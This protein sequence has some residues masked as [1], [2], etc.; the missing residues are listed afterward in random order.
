MLLCM[1]PWYLPICFVNTTQLIPITTVHIMKPI[2]TYSSLLSN[3][4]RDTN[5]AATANKMG[6][7]KKN[8][9]FRSEWSRYKIMII[10]SVKPYFFIV[11]S[12]L[13]LRLIFTQETFTEVHYW[14][15]PKGKL[16]W[17]ILIRQLMTQP[18]VI[19][20]SLKLNT[21]QGVSARFDL[22]V[23]HKPLVQ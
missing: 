21:R 17:L 16:F 2:I 20:H 23:K 8:I 4:I 22:R 15:T 5:M 11:K 3:H 18:L 9:F 12:Q 6:T 19:I 10:L 7:Q 1:G 14:D 13:S